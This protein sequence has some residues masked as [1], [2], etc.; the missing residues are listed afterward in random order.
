MVKI[1]GVASA[2]SA[3]A[4]DGMPEYL[5]FV[6]SRLVESPRS[7]EPQALAAL[8]GLARRSKRVAVLHGYSPREALALAPTLGVDVI[9]FHSP[10]PPEEAALLAGSLEPLGVALAPVVEWRG[11]RWEPMEPC[12]YLEALAGE[13]A[14]VEYLLLDAAKGLSGGFPLREAAR[15]LPC[16][17]RRGVALGVAGG[18]RPGGPVCEAARLGFHL[19]DVS[20]GVE[21]APGVKDP[22]LSALLI[23]EARRCSR[24]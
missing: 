5:G 11:G 9:Q 14:R 7:L 6:S 2:G 24:P 21:E 4:L 8:A 18:L 3:A 12:S 16:A 1:C 13:G 17:E 20:R 22:L 10:L 19:V 15:A 23:E